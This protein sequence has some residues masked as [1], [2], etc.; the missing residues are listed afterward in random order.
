M[1]YAQLKINKLELFRVD[2]LDAAQG[3]EFQI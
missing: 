3:M 2:L 1:S